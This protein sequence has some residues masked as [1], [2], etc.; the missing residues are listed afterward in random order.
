MTRKRPSVSVVVPFGGRARDTRDLTSAL[1]AINWRLD[2]EAIV[3][4]N[5][6]GGTFPDAPG[7]RVIHA[8]EQASS[9]YA[10]NV[11]TKTSTNPWV[12]FIDSDCRPRPTILDDYFNREIPPRCGILGGEVLPLR[13]DDDGVVSRYART[14]GHLRQAPHVQASRPFVVTANAL[15]RRAAYDDVGG[16]V[17][18]I[19]TAGDKDFSW[20][21]L[22][23]GWTIEY[24][25]DAIVEHRHRENLRDLF[26][27]WERYGTGNA[28]LEQRYPGT[29]PRRPVVR[30]LGGIG[31]LLVHA[32]AEL[33]RGRRPA[34]EVAALD[35]FVAT[36]YLIGPLKKNRAAV[37]QLTPRT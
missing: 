1:A 13:G 36:A 20:R 3:V 26:E 22:N 29:Y 15:V 34:A 8:F 33:S 14:R 28:W 23:G 31:K 17:E 24:A 12:L 7:I 9:Y 11:G 32:G 30:R 16:F 25:P 19:R 2:D 5:T 21:V 18:G 6:V 37:R 27:Q 10:R 4:D 35:A